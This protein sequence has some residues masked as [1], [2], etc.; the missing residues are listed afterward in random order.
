[1]EVLYARCCGLDVHKSSIMAC[2]RIQEQGG[3]PRKIVRRF[4]AMTADLRGMANWLLEQQVT[5]VGMESTGVYW[6]PVWNILEGQF[7]LILANAQHVKNVPGR[8]TDTKDSEWLA[9]L[10]QHGLLAGSF[11]PPRFIRD[12]RDANAGEPCT[13]IFANG[14]SD[15][16]ST[17]GRQYQVGERG[18]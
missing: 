6:K 13:G 8:K 9:E 15:P 14:Q 18:Q 5:H 16:K 11:V 3:K 2:V 10:L 17:R 4:G 1:M 7:T 12:L